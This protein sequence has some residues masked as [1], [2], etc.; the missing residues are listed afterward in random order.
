MSCHLLDSHCSLLSLHCSHHSPGVR[1]WAPALPKWRG[2]CQQRPL[3]LSCGLHR[4]AVW[5]AS[6][7]NRAGGLQRAQFGPHPADAPVLRHVATAAAGLSPA[8]RGPLLAHHALKGLM[9]WVE[10]WTPRRLHLNLP[11]PHLN[12]QQPLNK[13]NHV[14]SGLYCSELLRC[15]TLWTLTLTIEGMCQTNECKNFSFNIK[16]Y[17]DI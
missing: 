10:R 6:L 9:T 12:N 13:N 15:Q 11:F 2:V 8:E 4:P 3:Q 17:T 5:E 1:Q 7:R 16:E 14:L